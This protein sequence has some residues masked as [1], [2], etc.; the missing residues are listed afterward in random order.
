MFD[1][2]ASYFSCT[3]LNDFPP[4]HSRKGVDPTPY[5]RPYEA[6]V[7]G[8]WGW[9]GRCQGDPPT[10]QICGFSVNMSLCPGTADREGVGGVS[11]WV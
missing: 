9:W 4:T 6:R 2:E 7:H 10:P 3:S 11:R 5:Y 8:R 1:G